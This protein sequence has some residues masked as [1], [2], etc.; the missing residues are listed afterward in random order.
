MG[1]STVGSRSSA[2]NETGD[3]GGP[4]GML[5]ALVVDDK[6]TGRMLPPKA[7]GAA[8]YFTM[9]P[10]FE[11]DPDAGRRGMYIAKPLIS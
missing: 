3:D 5:R 11:P 1:T 8:S 10:R 4:P 7:K 6:I 9:V 2:R